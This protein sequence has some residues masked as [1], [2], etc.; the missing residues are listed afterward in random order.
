M[1]LVE[2]LKKHRWD[3]DRDP[4]SSGKMFPAHTYLEVYDRLFSVFKNEPINILEIGVLRGTSLQ[5][6]S[7]YFPNATIYG[8]DTFERTYWEGCRYEDVSKRFKDNPRVKL[9]K[10]SSCELTNMRLI[11]ERK[12]FLNSIPDGHFHIIIDD[13]SHELVDQLF[14]YKNFQ[15]KLHHDGIYVV[16]DIGWSSEA[17]FDPNVILEHIPELKMIDMRF[18][19]KHDNAIAIRYNDNSK[20][21]EYF[22]SYYD[23]KH[24]KTA[25]EFTEE[26]VMKKFRGEL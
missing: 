23:S 10:L 3:C 25:Y 20:H 14:T 24:W 18:G 9:V 6:W 17:S 5:L 4:H 11:K 8:A 22:Q 16:E 7:E 13:G 26:Y 2:I 15:S 12:A 1:T 19:D 21:Y